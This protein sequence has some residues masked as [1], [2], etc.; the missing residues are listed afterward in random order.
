MEL[1]ANVVAQLISRARL[2]LRDN[3]RGPALESIAAGS[4]S[5]TGRCRC[6]AR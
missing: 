3:L 2:K 1:N 4:P 6:S 5:A